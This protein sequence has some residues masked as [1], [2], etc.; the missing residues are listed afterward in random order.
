VAGVGEFINEKVDGE[1]KMAGV[2]GMWAMVLSSHLH[3]SPIKLPLVRVSPNYFKRKKS[4][5][6]SSSLWILPT[7]SNSR[8]PHLP[9]HPPLFVLQEIIARGHEAMV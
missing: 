8:G 7:W 5:I 6:H 4:I 9:S 2:H 1:L 3:C